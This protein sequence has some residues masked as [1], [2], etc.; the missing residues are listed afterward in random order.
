MTF[1]IIEKGSVFNYLKEK[2]YELFYDPCYIP[3]ADRSHH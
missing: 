3:L 1:L 2:L